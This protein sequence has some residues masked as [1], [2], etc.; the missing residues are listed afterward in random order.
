MFVFFFPNC[1][2]I[3]SLFFRC[4]KCHL[5]SVH[6]SFSSSLCVSMCSC[7]R[8][9]RCAALCL[10]HRKCFYSFVYLLFIEDD[11]KSCSFYSFCSPWD[12]TRYQ[13]LMLMCEILAFKK[14]LIFCPDKMRPFSRF[15]SGETPII[16]THWHL[17][18][19]EFMD[20]FGFSDEDGFSMAQGFKKSKNR[21]QGRAMLKVASKR[22]HKP[23]CDNLSCL[24]ISN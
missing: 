20:F 13:M 22:S 21:N 1:S 18:S 24:G 23:Y 17:A 9:L 12:D 5:G 8:H 15:Y 7:S 14:R 6:V 16:R 19:F 4:Q 10:G 11:Y 3:L 2:G